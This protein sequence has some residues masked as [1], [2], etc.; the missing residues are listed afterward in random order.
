MRHIMRLFPRAALFFAFLVTIGCELFNGGGYNWS[1]SF[2]GTCGEV[3]QLP[4]GGYVVSRR[5][6]SDRDLV[7]LLR[8]DSE[9]G[10]RWAVDYDT[11]VTWTTNS[12][13]TT[14]D[15]GFL[16]TQGSP[17]GG[18]TRLTR[19]D[20]GGGVVWRLN[21]TGLDHSGFSVYHYQDDRCCPTADGGYVTTG[22]LEDLIALVKVS[23]DG[24]E[25][26]RASGDSGTGNWV[27]QTSDHG[28]LVACYA[29]LCKFDSART[30][31]WSRNLRTVMN[32]ISYAY[33]DPG[34]ECVLASRNAPHIT[35]L[36]AAGN[37]TWQRNVGQGHAKISSV[38]PTSDGGF[39][40]AGREHGDIVLVKTDSLGI[41]EWLREFGGDKTEYGTWAEQTADGGYIVAGYDVSY[42]FINGLPYA[43]TVRLKKT[44]ANGD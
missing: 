9:F 22:G 10:P 33:L 42:G 16:I 31:V 32:P 30:V 2:D 1:A 39:I 20:S 23:S 6:G 5:H 41:E 11:S 14:A 8:T 40:L 29:K 37:V 35:K 36:D 27:V 17:Y 44:D 18:H 38:Q 26:W 25:E 3:H 4:D 15:D 13:L 34:G 7:G 19:T 12:V 21:I 43:W 28:Y 24:T